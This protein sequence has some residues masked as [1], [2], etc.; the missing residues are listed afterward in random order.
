M[1]SREQA[2]AYR[3]DAQGLRERADAGR[4]MA[5]ATA[6]CVQNTPPGAAGQ[7]LAARVADISEGDVVAALEED[8]SLLQ[9]FGARAAPHVFATTD[10]PVFTLGLLPGDEAA[11]RKFM[12]G[13]RPALDTVGIS[14]TELVRLSGQAVEEVLDGTGLVKDDLGPGD[15]AWIATSPTW[16]TRPIC[17]S[18]SSPDEATS[19]STCSTTPYPSIPSSP[20]STTTRSRLRRSTSPRPR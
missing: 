19:G 17:G 13:A 14:A 15:E 1:I 3:L 12:L 10:A 7:A 11:L 2:I 9:A 16:A 18:M 5:V 20:T 8:K 6:I 4:M